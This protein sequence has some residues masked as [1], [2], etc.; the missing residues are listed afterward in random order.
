MKTTSWNIF[1]NYNANIL[2]II[3]LVQEIRNQSICAPFSAATEHDAQC[4]C[5][6]VGE[7]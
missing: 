5:I 1:N 7:G 6:L 4:N 2:L 3:K